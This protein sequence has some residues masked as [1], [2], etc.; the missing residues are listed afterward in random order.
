MTFDEALE[1]LVQLTKDHGG[2][3]GGPYVH[4]LPERR[5]FELPIT[6]LTGI[7]IAL[8]TS[9]KAPVAERVDGLKAVG[10]FLMSTATRETR[11]HYEEIPLLVLVKA[12]T[13]LKGRID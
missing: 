3:G 2:N 8:V 11:V 10:Q 1:I 6:V 12:L 13:P 4:L 7:E 5:P 9:S